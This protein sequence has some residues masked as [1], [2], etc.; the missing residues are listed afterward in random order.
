MKLRAWRAKRR[1]GISLTHACVSAKTARRYYAAF[2]L[3]LP[4]LNQ[5]CT[6]DEVDCV[7]AEWVEAQFTS[8]TILSTV[9]DA[10]SGFHH[11]LPMTKRKLAY[12]WRLLRTWRKVEPPCRAIPLPVDLAKAGIVAAILSGELYL[13]AL[14]CLGFFCMLRTGELLKVRKQDL[15][16]RRRKAVVGLRC[17]KSGQQNAAMEAVSCDNPRAVEI[18]QLCVEDQSRSPGSTLWQGSPQSFRAAF[19]RL[20]KRLG[21]ENFSFKPYSLR[22]GGATFLLQSHMPLE[23]ILLRGRW[24]SA[25]VA[26]IYLQDGLA[27]LT[28]IR[29]P[30]NVAQHVQLLASQF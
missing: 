20:L 29:M 1:A 26:R 25:S 11:F 30:N 23:Y 15:L 2:S 17:T 7:T 24:R 28:E 9:A 12:T 4:H 14:L 21:V 16:V 8:G 13:A 3:L 22:R 18:L 10:L 27:A 19:A 6:M 5:A